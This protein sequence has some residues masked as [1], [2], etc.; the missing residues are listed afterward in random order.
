MRL[1]CYILQM[2]STHQAHILRPHLEE[3][4]GGTEPPTI[5]TV[6]RDEAELDVWVY[7]SGSDIHGGEAL[8]AERRV[9]FLIPPKLEIEPGVIGKY[10]CR[11]LEASDA[12]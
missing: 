3:W 10:A 11:A 9:Q 7:S 6:N 12:R 1:W 4:C 2:T 8:T 5:V